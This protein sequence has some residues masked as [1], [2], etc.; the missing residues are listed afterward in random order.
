MTIRGTKM[1]FKKID[2]K[3]LGALMALVGIM[4]VLWNLHEN[5]LLGLALF[6]LMIAEGALLIGR[7]D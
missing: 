6:T 2:D 3:K 1:R 5:R 7:S 4:G